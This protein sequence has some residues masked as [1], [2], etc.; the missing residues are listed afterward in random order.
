MSFNLVYDGNTTALDR[1]DG[2]LRTF[3][4]NA[5]QL[6]ATIA[7]EV[8]A[9][10][11]AQMLEALQ[12]YPPVPAGS[13]YVRTFRLRR[14]FQLTL[15]ISGSALYVVVKN[16]TPYT[17]WVVG[18]LSNIDSVAR[19]TQRAFHARNGWPITL[20]TTR[21]WFDRYKDA[22]IEAFIEA[23]IEDARKRSE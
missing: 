5:R 21:F 9:E 13:T 19:S 7:T 12:F 4:E 23:V 15:E 11:R 10:I 18:T 14:G 3:D 20:T 8:F 6:F 16:Q 17:R 1:L 22:F 2:Y